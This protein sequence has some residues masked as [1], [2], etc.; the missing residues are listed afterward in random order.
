MASRK[1][2]MSKNLALILNAS[3]L[4]LYICFVNC[5]ML[6]F[7]DVVDRGVY[8][9][10]P[11]I[12]YPTK[13]ELVSG[14]ELVLIA[15]LPVAVFI[16]IVNYFTAALTKLPSPKDSYKLSNLLSFIKVT[17]ICWVENLIVFLVFTA[18]N[19]TCYLITDITKIAV[20]EYRPHFLAVCKPNDLPFQDWDQLNCK[21]NTLMTRD[22]FNCAAD[23]TELE[24]A[25]KSFPSG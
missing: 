21:Y 17:K 23:L 10:D 16:M 24:D 4:L 9:G 8:C 3:G 19:S 11:S 14:S 18:G 15:I 5:I 25:M 6:T 13:K 20:G 1:A 7:P 2:L 22:S 12:I